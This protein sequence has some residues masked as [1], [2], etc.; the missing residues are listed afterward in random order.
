MLCGG[1]HVQCTLSVLSA[2]FYFLLVYCAVAQDSL[3][4]GDG[5][6]SG[7]ASRGSE[8]EVHS[9]ADARLSGNSYTAVCVCVCVCVHA[10]C[11]I[12]LCV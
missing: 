8:C 7:E 11:F 5:W 1:G 6:I 3:H 4:S 2:V 10:L 12:C 9:A